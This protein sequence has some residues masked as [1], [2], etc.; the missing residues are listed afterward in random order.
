ML[1]ILR[2]RAWPYRLLRIGAL[3]ALGWFVLQW[4]LPMV[5][6]TLPW[7]YSWPLTDF[8][9]VTINLEEIRSG[10]PPKDGIPAIDEPKFVSSKEAD[11]WLDAREPV[12]VVQRQGRARAY[13]LQILIYHEIV[14]DEFEG[15]PLSVTFCP[16]CN[17]SI[18]F[19]RRVAG[20]VL[21]FGT[22]GKLRKSDLVMYDR[23]TESWWQQFT[24]TGIVGHYAGTRL[25]QVPSQ[26]VAYEDFKA[27]YPVGAVLSRKTG[28]WRPYG[29]NPYR[30]YDRVGDQPFLFSDPVD[31]RLPA[32]ER[33]LGVIHAERTRIYPFSEFDEKGVINDEFAGLPLVV[34]YE[35]STLSVLDRASITS[36][37]LVH[38]ANGFDRR[39]GDRVLHFERAAAAFVDR[40]TGSQWNSLGH[41]TG[42]PLKGARL[43]AVD[44][45]VHFAF[46]WLAFR[47]NTEIY[48]KR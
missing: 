47:P 33:V 19:D 21:D 1:A 39:V 8:S 31:R 10:G 13:P 25:R 15:L 35:R 43:Q 40:E 41:A 46:A 11:D 30:G 45:G 16:L 42:G 32:M 3:V 29:N 38:A 26:I 23:Q 4:V 28:Y 44:N 22:T 24:G 9:R 18:V 20:R 27:A 2:S 37:R 7:K 17:A 5:R 14:N 34:F 6:T 12:I 48:K 36:S